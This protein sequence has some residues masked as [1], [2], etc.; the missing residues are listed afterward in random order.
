MPDSVCILGL[1]TALAACSAAVVRGGRTLAARHEEIGRGHAERL[2][3]MI[4][5][6]M[7]EARGLGVDYPQLAAV[8]VTVGPGA[9]TG[10]RIG[11]SAARALA[12]ALDRPVVPVT[13]FEAVAVASLTAAPLAVGAL[14]AVLHDARRGEVYVECQRYLGADDAG[15]AWVESVGAARA[16]P[17]DAVLETLDPGL[18]MALGSGVPL[19]RAGLL[20]RGLQLRDEPCYPDAV[21]VAAIAARILRS[22]TVLVPA[23]PLYLRAPDAKL[24]GGLT[25]A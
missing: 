11:L 14:F 15:L 24:P 2:M 21:W 19:L 4:E 6:I 3:P 10:L 8:A 7:A 12:L 22:G 23:R 1:D 17:L 18:S 9:F 16:V 20:D 25:L 5:E 13:S